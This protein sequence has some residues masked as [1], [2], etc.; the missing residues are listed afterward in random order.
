MWLRVVT[1]RMQLRVRD[2]RACMEL[3][4]SEISFAVRDKCDIVVKGQSIYYW[5]LS[6]DTHSKRIWKV[7]VPSHS[8]QL[9]NLL[10]QNE[11]V[12]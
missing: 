7:I 5:G 8:N 2:L 10:L 11:V 12:R 9:L 4:T 6:T 1:F 3:C